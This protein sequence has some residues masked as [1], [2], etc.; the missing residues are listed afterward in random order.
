[1]E[2]QRTQKPE[3]FIGGP[4]Y[5]YNPSNQVTTAYNAVS[6]SYT[7]TDLQEIKSMV[8]RSR[9]SAVGAQNGVNGVIRSS[10]DL[11]ASFQFDKTRQ[12]HS[13]QFDRPIQTA[14]SYYDEVLFSFG[15]NPIKR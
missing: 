4:S 6:S 9:S 11:K 13:A 12:E 8:A 2:D 10:V 1:V 14:W 15:I 5:V 7:V 3:T